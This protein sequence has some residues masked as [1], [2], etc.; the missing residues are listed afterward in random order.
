MP[1][2]GTV[3]ATLTIGDVSETIKYGGET[4]FSFSNMKLDE[5]ALEDHVSLSVEYY[6]TITT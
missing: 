5:T 6:K 2:E 1:P 4:L 3:S